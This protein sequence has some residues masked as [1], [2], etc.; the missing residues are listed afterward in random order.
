MVSETDLEKPLGRVGT[1][2]LVLLA[3]FTSNFITIFGNKTD[4]L[5]YISSF[6]FFLF[7]T[8]YIIIELKILSSE[9]KFGTYA[10]YAAA[11]AIG[12]AIN[13]FT[14]T[15]LLNPQTDND[16]QS[17]I[18]IISL[19]NNK[20]DKTDFYFANILEKSIF[21]RIIGCSR[22]FEGEIPLFYGRVQKGEAKKIEN[23]ENDKPLY[24][25]ILRVIEKN[26]L[27]TSYS[28]QWNSLSDNINGEIEKN[29]GDKICPK[30]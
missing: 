1:F 13:A 2:A 29:A 26:N 17:P 22:Y 28:L 30:L 27:I 3:G 6:L 23:L 12:S 5:F 11:V 14:P 9:I 18:N 7:I 25:V 4:I 19:H 15:H 24:L 20:N 8:F 21:V 10:I 16:S